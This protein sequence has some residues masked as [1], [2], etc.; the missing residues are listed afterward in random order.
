MASNQP[1]ESKLFSLADFIREIQ[2]AGVLASKVRGSQF[3]VS[4]VDEQLAINGNRDLLFSALCNLLQNAFKFTQVHTE[5]SL[6][7]YALG[8]RIMIDVKDH[9]GGLAPGTKE[10]MFLPYSQHSTDKTGIGL[11]LSI[12]Q[13]C[14]AADGG[15]LSVL[16]VPGTGCIFSISLP[17]Q[18]LKAD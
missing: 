5:V 10:N 9:C 2:S 3:I 15:T 1:Q 12:A 8:D 7:A 16:D 17:R 13:E 11:G 14:V 18:E 4:A 6:D